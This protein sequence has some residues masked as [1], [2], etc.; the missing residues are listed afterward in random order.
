METFRARAGSLVFFFSCIVLHGHPVALASRRGLVVAPGV[1]ISFLSFI[2]LC[3]VLIPQLFP[4]VSWLTALSSCSYLGHGG[5]FLARR[6]HLRTWISSSYGAWFPFFLRS[7]FFCVGNGRKRRTLYIKIITSLQWTF[8]LMS[9]TSILCN[10][11][12]SH[13]R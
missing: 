8:N 5:A 1:L 3:T 10:V 11:S 13:Y 2:L 12:C 9:L 4:L 6:S 7:F